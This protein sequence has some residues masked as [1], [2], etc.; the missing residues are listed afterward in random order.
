MTLTQKA[1]YIANK[2]AD[3]YSFDRY[4]SWMSVARELLKLGW[5]PIEVEAFMRSKHTRWAG[6]V[7]G[8]PYGKCTGNDVLRYL[9]NE[10]NM[11]RGIQA[12]LDELVAGTWSVN[13]QPV[14]PL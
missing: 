2:C 12:E 8:K 14:Y 5:K 6:D 13:D 9:E 4:S 3:A 10:R 1:Q 7:S 11:P